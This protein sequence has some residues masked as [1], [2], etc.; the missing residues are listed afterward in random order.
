MLAAMTVRSRLDGLLLVVHG[1]MG[2]RRIIHN[3]VRVHVLPR[4]M[5]LPQY[6]FVHPILVKM[7]LQPACIA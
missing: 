3:P 4:S 1:S 7:R 5:I 6:V 2:Q